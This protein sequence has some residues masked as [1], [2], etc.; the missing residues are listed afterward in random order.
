MELPKPNDQFVRLMEIKKE[1][2]QKQK[3]VKK[4][5]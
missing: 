3:K 5:E 2:Q 4:V 1:H